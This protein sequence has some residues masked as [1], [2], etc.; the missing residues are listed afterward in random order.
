ME[1]MCESVKET[2]AIEEIPGE[3]RNNLLSH[4]F[5]KVRKLNGLR[6]QQLHYCFAQ[7]SPPLPLPNRRRVVIDSDEDDCA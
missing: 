7:Q 6:L 4:F 2:K 3:E 5:D 1:T